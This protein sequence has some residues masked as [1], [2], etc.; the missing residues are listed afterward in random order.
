R[1]LRKPN[2]VRRLAL[3]LRYADDVALRLRVPET[4]DE[5]AARIVSPLRDRPIDDVAD[6]MKRL[7]RLQALRLEVDISPAAEEYVQ[8]RLAQDRLGELVAAIR[9]NPAK[10]RLR[11]SLLKV[12]L[13]PYQLDGI[14]FAVGAGRAVLADDMG[15]G[16]TIQGVGVAEL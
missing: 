15:L 10:H 9:S 7:A 3:H 11:A 14:A 6:L 4:L 2:R 12:P 13:L 5:A 16:K 8:Q 1:A